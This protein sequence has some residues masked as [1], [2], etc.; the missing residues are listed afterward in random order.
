MKQVELEYQE[1]KKIMVDELSKLGTEGLYQRAILATSANDQ[2]SARRMWFVPDNL[3][4]YCYTDRGTRKVQQIES[5][6]NIAVVAGF[7]Q[8]EGT[9]S[10]KKHP[11]DESEF[12]NLYEEKY[13][14]KYD[15]WRSQPNVTRERDLV[16]IEVKP[17][18]IAMFH[19]GDPV[20]GIA[21]GLYVLN[22]EKGTAHRIIDVISMESRP[23]EAP[24]YVV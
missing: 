21:R 3:T 15:N 22:V 13:P 12:L 10:L 16:L 8:V 19:Y 5:N 20:L 7:V 6:P 23:S 11:F 9:A 17:R 4:L 18:R 1:L 2:V 14:E 24:A